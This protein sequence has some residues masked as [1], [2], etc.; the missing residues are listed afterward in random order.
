MV[1]QQI[2]HFSDNHDDED[3]WLCGQPDSIEHR[4]LYCQS[5]AYV[6]AQY[7]E[8]I[9]HLQDHHVCHTTFPAV[10]APPQQDFFVWYHRQKPKPLLNPEIL[11]DMH[12]ESQTGIRPILFTDGSC[13]HPAEPLYRQASF[14]IVYHASVTRHEQCQQIREFLETKR[15]PQ[16]FQVLTTADTVG[17]QSIPRAELQAVITLLQV[18]FGIDVYTDSQYVIH[19]FSMVRSAANIA[20]LH[21][22]PNFDLLLQIDQSLHMADVRLFKVKSHAINPSE[23]ISDTWLK[24]GNEAADQAAK[25]TLRASAPRLADMLD[26][27]DHLQQVAMRA[28]HYQYL[29]DLQRARAQIL[30]ATDLPIPNGSQ[31]LPWSEQVKILATWRH[32]ETKQYNYNQDHANVADNCLWG[33]QYMLEILHWLTDVHWPVD[34]SDEPMQAG[35]SWFELA[36]SFSICTQKGLMV[37]GGF[38]GPQ[39]IPRRL[40]YNDPDVNFGLQV[41]SFERAVTY[42]STLLDCPLFH[43]ERQLSRAVRFLGAE[44]GKAGLS[45][46]PQ[47]PFQEEITYML[48]NHWKDQ[49]EGPPVLPIK[50]PC[51]VIPTSEQD[52]LDHLDGWKPTHQR[53]R[54]FKYG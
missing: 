49:C 13:D 36:I 8:L 45:V 51:V 31:R 16:T 52:R 44:Q 12:L 53:S 29:E 37:N 54:R 14:A 32:A 15:I 21:T 23:A 41:R 25:E 20:L 9:A 11:H 39:F 50:E 18:P 10:Y 24:L 19:A 42:V 4:V 1:G 28:Q 26:L 35:V 46:R 22:Q 5:T 43:G 33:I 27:S 40:E 30:Q 17:E 34:D 38:R 2:K 48:H 7:P 6:R 3:C 47:F